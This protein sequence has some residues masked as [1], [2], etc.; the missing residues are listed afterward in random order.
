VT[1]FGSLTILCIAP[2]MRA[3][4]TATVTRDAGEV[5]REMCE[6]IYQ[7]TLR[8]RSFST[9]VVRFMPSNS[10]ARFLLPPVRSSA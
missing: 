10:A 3:A 6:R 1:V 8:R 5:L 4:A 7:A 9:N 2:R